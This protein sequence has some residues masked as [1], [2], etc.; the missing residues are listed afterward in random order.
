MIYGAAP[1]GPTSEQL[2][3]CSAL[4]ATRQGIALHHYSTVRCSL[5]SLVYTLHLQYESSRLAHCATWLLSSDDARALSVRFGRSPTRS[6]RTPTVCDCLRAA[7]N[8]L[9]RCGFC[10]AFCNFYRPLFS[11]DDKCSAVCQLSFMVRIQRNGQR[12]AVICCVANI[13]NT[14]FCF[15]CENGVFFFCLGNLLSIY[16]GPKSLVK[17]VCDFMQNEVFLFS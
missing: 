5:Q 10:S 15:V 1:R 11:F 12:S 9:L 7:A 4:A 16:S 17:Q 2:H 3:V 8:L 13:P 14:Q 6:T